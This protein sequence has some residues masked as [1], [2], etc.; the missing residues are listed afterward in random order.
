M[1]NEQLKATLQQHLNAKINEE[2]QIPPTR[3]LRV[4]AGRSNS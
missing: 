2:L 3:L 1:Q 4:D